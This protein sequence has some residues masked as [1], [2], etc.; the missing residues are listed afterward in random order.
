MQ[1]D[2]DRAASNNL[3]MRLAPNPPI[4]S[5]NSDPFIERK[6]TVDSAA[7]ALAN[8]VFPHPGGPVRRAPLGSLAPSFYNMQIKIS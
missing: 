4:I 1:G 3:R 7:S 5:T 2:L 8:K 6:G